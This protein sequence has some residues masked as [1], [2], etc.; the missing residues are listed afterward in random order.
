MWEVNSY[1]NIWNMNKNN[2][3]YWVPILRPDSPAS[4]LVSSRSYLSHCVRSLPPEY[5]RNILAFLTGISLTDISALP[6]LYKP[7]APGQIIICGVFLKNILKHWKPFYR[8]CVMEH[9]LVTCMQFTGRVVNVFET[10]LTTYFFLHLSPRVSTKNKINGA[11]E[12]S[13]TGRILAIS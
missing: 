7:Q 3:N 1:L 6:S 13:H 9:C 5:Q 10:N 12:K 11:W 4:E 8:S 2:S